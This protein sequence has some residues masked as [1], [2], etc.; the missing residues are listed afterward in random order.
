MANQLAEQIRQLTAEKINFVDDNSESVLKTVV[1]SA[2]E[3]DDAADAFV[4]LTGDDVDQADIA[5]GLVD[6]ADIFDDSEMSP[7]STARLNAVVDRLLKTGSDEQKASAKALFTKTLS[8]GLAAKATN[9]YFDEL[10]ST[11]PVE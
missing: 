8:Y 11:P 3:L 10:L 2:L 5:S 1:S 4:A 6:L 9:D 7:E